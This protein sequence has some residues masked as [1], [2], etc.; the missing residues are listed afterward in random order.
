MKVD[1]VM[2]REVVAVPPGASLKDAAHLLVTHRISGLPVVDRDGRVIGVVS[3]RDLL[4]KERGE[5]DV[6]RTADRRKLEGHVVGDVMTMPP[7]TIE[8]WRT[9]AVAAKLMLDA[10][11]HRLPVVEDGRLVGIVSRAD[12]IRAFTRSDAEIAREIRD[13]VLAHTMRVDDGCVA[14]EVANGE[15]FLTGAVETHADAA[16]LPALVAK[17]PGVVEV[18]ARLTWSDVDL[19]C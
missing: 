4:F 5:V 8:P 14:V 13:D 7:R 18:R 10:D 12:L 17:V 11:V 15:V 3:E 9:V 16:L 2:T 1:S 19:E 6:D